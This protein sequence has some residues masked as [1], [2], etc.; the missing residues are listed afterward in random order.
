MNKRSVNNIKPPEPTAQ[1]R[2]TALNSYS[3]AYWQMKPKWHAALDLFEPVYSGATGYGGGSRSTLTAYLTQHPKEDPEEFSRRANRVAQ[4]NVIKLILEFYGSMLFSNA[5]RYD[6]DPEHKDRMMAFV[7]SCN[8]QGDT[9]DEFYREQAWIQSA[10]FGTAD[11]FVDLPQRSEDAKSLADEQEQ[12]LSDPYVFIIPPL[13]RVR[14]QVDDAGNYTFYQSKDVIDEEINPAFVI[15]QKTQYQ[16]WNSQTVST[17]DKNG[18]LTG[19][20]KNTH[21]FIPAVTITPIPS[22]RF[23]NE[24]I[25][26]SLVDGLVELQTIII[27]TLSMIDD[28]HT[29]IN[30]S[31]LTVIQDTSNGDEPPQEGDGAEFGN[32]R[33]A[34]FRGSGTK[35]G[36]VS[37]DPQGV[38][39][40]QEYLDQ[41]ICKM[42][43]MALVP[44]DANSIKTHTSSNT[45]RSNLSQLYNR[46]TSIAKH[47]EKSMKK[48]IETALKIQGIDPK[49]AKVNVQLPTDYSYESLINAIE[50][51]AALKATA[52]DISNTAIREFTKKVIAPVLY[53]TGKLDAI[54]A[55]IDQWVFTP[56]DAESSPSDQGKASDDADEEG[57]D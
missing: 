17:F 15:K 23:P 52:G 27:N 55:E 31:L 51:L 48:V 36:F 41:I 34:A 8:L 10:L 54:N 3:A 49:D 11:V 5:T 57:D 40:M 25:G 24:K 33:I 38:K 18:T 39:A 30:F 35:V 32:H 44:K 9:L 37:P 29:A 12:G 46:L 6:C 19:S 21:G 43:D 22:I 26:T 45:I 13:N 28:F 2:A 1:Q 47:L 42:F 4:V 16:C 53:N 20:K 50:Q 7:N 14:W 56:P